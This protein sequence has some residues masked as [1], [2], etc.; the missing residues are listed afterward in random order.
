MSSNPESNIFLSDQLLKVS[1]PI[2]AGLIAYMIYWF[3]QESGRLKTRLISKFGEDGGSVKL[4]LG[5]KYLG[6]I[7]LGILPFIA[8]RIA[9]PETTLKEFGVWLNTE[10]VL[11]S[12]LLILSLGGIMVFIIYML[13]KSPNILAKQ[14][15]I[16]MKEWPH[17]LLYYNLLAWAVY[18]LGYEFFFRGVLLFPLV[19]S[20]GMWPAIGVNM[21][22]YAGVHL[23]KGADEA[24]G[25]I[26]L[27]FVLCLLTIKTG[28]IWIAY[29]VHL[30]MA[31]TMTISALKHQPEMSVIKLMR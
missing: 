4:I 15:E 10:T 18:L 23:P 27:A 25:A 31:W 19:D 8:Y 21:I 28:T 17:S 16:R 2:V 6:A 14:P 5:A 1:I 12:I 24:I 26:P 22:F 9:F 3:T 13:S 29:F 20:I 7:S 30:A 11:F